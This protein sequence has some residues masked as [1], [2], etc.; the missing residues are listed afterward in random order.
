MARALATPRAKAL[1]ADGVLF[2]G[3]IK[4]CTIEE[5]VIV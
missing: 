4:T 3:R 1:Y 2:I 5:K